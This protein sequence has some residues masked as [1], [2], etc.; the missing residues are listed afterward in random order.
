MAKDAHRVTHRGAHGLFDDFD[1][2]HELHHVQ[3]TSR[4]EVRMAE[5]I[6]RGK[7]AESKISCL[8]AKVLPRND[9]RDGFE[10][11]D[12][13]KEDLSKGIAIVV[14]G[15]AISGE[16]PVYQNRGW[17]TGAVESPWL[18]EC[19]MIRVKSDNPGGCHIV[20]KP[21]ILRDN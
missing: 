8:F 4:R 3:K 19:G 2:V 12:N 13:G 16:D 14:N 20:A 11:F 1:E 9:K 7:P 5:R 18:K 15:K 17:D 10:R 21:F 6:A